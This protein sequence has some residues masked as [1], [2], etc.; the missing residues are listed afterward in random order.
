[1]NGWDVSGV[2]DMSHMFENA[3]SFNQPIGGWD[4]SNVTSMY[5]MFEGASSFN[6][7]ISLK[8]R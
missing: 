6:Q 8:K 3:S 4:V 7:P 2:I 1:M 5:A